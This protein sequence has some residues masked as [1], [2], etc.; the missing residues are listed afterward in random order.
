MN[1]SKRMSLHRILEILL[2]GCVLLFAV[3]L[4]ALKIVHSS[5]ASKIEVQAAKEV[6]RYIFLRTGRAPEVIS[7]NRY[8]DLP[9][10]DVIVVAADNKFIIAEL[11]SEYGNVDAP[12][13]DNRNGYI[14]KSIT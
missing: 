13:S 12:D 5:D 14:L 8:A 10:G 6:R 7:A 3:P 1:S 2:S 4:K 11:K 9:D